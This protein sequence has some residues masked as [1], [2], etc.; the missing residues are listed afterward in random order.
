MV[1][2]SNIFNERKKTDRDIKCSIT[3]GICARAKEK[4]MMVLT[5]IRL[6]LCER[7]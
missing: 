5:L 2:T 1:G 6:L 3:R 7:D 4:Y